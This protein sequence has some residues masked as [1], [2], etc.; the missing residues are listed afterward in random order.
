MGMC[1]SGDIFQDKVDDPLG[2]IESVKTYINDI[3]VLC[4]DIFEKHIYQLII[5]FS[6]LRAAGL[7][8]NA[9]KCS[10]GLKEITYLGYVITR[11]Y[12]KPDPK[13]VQGIMDIGRPSTTTEAQVLIGMVQYYRDMCSRWSHILSPLTEAYSGPKGRKILWNDALESSFKVLKRMVSAETMISDPDWKLP[14][15]VHSNASDKK[16]GAA[17]SQNNKPIAFFSRELIKPQLNYTTT[18]KELLAIVECLKQFR[19]IIF[20]YEIN[21]LSYH[22]NMV[23]SATLSE[24][25]KVMRWQLILK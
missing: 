21:V 2:N 13:K 5:I 7:R 8:V 18:K 22:K 16:L 14:F 1:A 3:L 4:K 19:G 10:F 11:E 9:P 6:R 15:T 17:I 24:S 23:F 12:I 20:G 25:Q